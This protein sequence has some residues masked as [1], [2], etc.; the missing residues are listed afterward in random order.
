[1]DTKEVR[2]VDVWSAAKLSAAIY[3]VFAVIYGIIAMIIAVFGMAAIPGTSAVV[4]LVGGIIA[5]LISV[6][7]VA[8][9]GMIIGFIFGAIAAFIYNLAAGVF[10]GLKIDLE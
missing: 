7:I 2:H 9:L 8:V 4:T 6:V 3:L 5:M 1:M 10:G